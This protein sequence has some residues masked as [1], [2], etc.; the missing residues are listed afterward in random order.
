MAGFVQV[1]TYISAFF[2]NYLFNGLSG[3]HNCWGNTLL[4]LQTSSGIVGQ[5]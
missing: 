2:D 3:N 4:V 5:K 1:G